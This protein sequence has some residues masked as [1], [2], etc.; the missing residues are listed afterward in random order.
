MA[1]RDS[2][3]CKAYKTHRKE[4]DGVVIMKMRKNGEGPTSYSDEDS[5]SSNSSSGSSGHFGISGCCLM[6]NDGCLGQQNPLFLRGPGS[7]M[8]ER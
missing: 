5:S 7:S 8:T 4:A 1:A 3:N 6:L 2:Y